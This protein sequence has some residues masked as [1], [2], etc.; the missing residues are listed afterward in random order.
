M[1]LLSTQQAADGRCAG[2]GR[3]GPDAGRDRDPVGRRQRT[4]LPRRGPQERLPQDAP[5]LRLANLLEL[6]HPLSVDLHVERVVA[7][8]RLVVLRLLGGRGYWP[9]GVEQVAAS[10][11][12]HG[13][14]LACLPGDD[15]A[16]PELAELSTLPA[17]ALDRLWRYLGHGGVDNAEQALRYGASLIGRDLPFAEPRPLPRGLY[18]PP[19]RTTTAIRATTGHGRSSCSTGPCSR[20]AI[21]PRSTPWPEHSR[22]RDWRRRASMS[23]A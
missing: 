5:S 12:A 19:G 21:W 9:Y 6:A 7:Q 4:R 3:S 13:V 15:R 18:L 10:C 8:A 23:A 20:A 16:D 17:T 1:H 2:R 14:A 22:P 11:R